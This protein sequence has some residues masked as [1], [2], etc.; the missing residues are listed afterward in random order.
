[1][2]GDLGVEI[3]LF[4]IDAGPWHFGLSNLTLHVPRFEENPSKARKRRYREFRAR[5][6][7]IS[8]ICATQPVEAIKRISSRFSSR[9]GFS[10]VGAQGPSQGPGFQI[11]DFPVTH[12]LGDLADPEARVRLGGQDESEIS[13][14]LLYGPDVLAALIRELKPD[15][16]HSMEFQHAGYLVLAARDRMNEGFP[17]WLATNWGSDILYFGRILRHA[18]QIRRLCQAIDFYSCECYRDT[19]Y[20]RQ[21][22]Y[23]GPDLPVLPNSG[24]MDIDHVLSL[25]NAFPPSRRNLIMVKGYDHFAGRAMMSLELLERFS[26]RL[27]D[28]TIILYS[29]S[30]RPRDRAL[31]LAKAG[32]LN[33][34]V[35]IDLVPHDT[36]LK[37][38]GLARIYL[39]ISESDAISTSVLEAMAMGAFPIQTDTSCCTE[40]FIDNET[41]FSVPADD[42]DKICARFATALADDVLVDSAAERNFEIIKSRLDLKVVTPRV[43]EFY[44]L[45]LATSPEKSSISA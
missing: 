8:L 41:G 19:A 28:Y 18:R 42:M 15:L 30:P 4:P 44:S 43:H 2:I 17:R 45:A 31:E 14:S 13:T 22:G 34:E 33:I 32:V 29:A 6:S 9:L 36:I 24:G 16:I 39:G 10:D 35:I 21:F 40:W 20:A 11:R 25:R 23:S 5:A 3:H 1:M 27:K 7:R 37:Y 26:D 38:F 12:L